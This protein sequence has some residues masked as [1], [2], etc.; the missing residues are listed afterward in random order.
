MDEKLKIMHI[1]FIKF[2]EN[3][4]LKAFESDA[5]GIELKLPEELS[6]AVWE[7]LALIKE[8]AYPLPIIVTYSPTWKSERLEEI[9]TK[10]A[11]FYVSGISLKK[12]IDARFLSQLIRASHLGLSLLIK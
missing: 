10:L 6:E 1:K 2:D 11:V 3:E 9:L 12:N 7:K 5:E 8:I 4:A